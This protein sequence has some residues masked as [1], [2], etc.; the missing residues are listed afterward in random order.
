MTGIRPRGDIL[1]PQIALHEAGHCVVARALGARIDAVDFG[2]VYCSN[3]GRHEDNACIMFAG[4]EAERIMDPA[5]N[6]ASAEVDDQA[7]AEALGAA[8]GRRGPHLLREDEA[9]PLRERAATILVE[10]WTEVER[11]AG[12][13]LEVRPLYGKDVERV[14]AASED[15]LPEIVSD[16][17]RQGRR[18]PPQ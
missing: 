1:P 15:A 4:L 10:R 3:P 13:L 16:L 18:R 14:L 9:R 17:R 6:P 8:Y 11:V 12:V 2:G 7:A 5:A